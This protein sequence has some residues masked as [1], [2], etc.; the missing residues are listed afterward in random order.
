MINKQWIAL[1]GCVMVC[2]VGVPA[3]NGQ[4]VTGLLQEAGQRFAEGKT[5]EARQRYEAVV[6]QDSSCYEALAWLGNYFYLKGSDELSALER[7][8]KGV[9][10][11]TRMQ[12][13]RH[14][15]QL[16]A[17]YTQWY[18]KAEACINKALDVRKN[19]HLQHLLDEMVRFKERQGLLKA[20]EPRRRF[21]LL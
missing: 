17:V 21:R 7:A 14:Q 18:A 12:V 3:A 4:T 5:E 16:K 13:A 1:V 6:A 19:E 20:V 8:Y 9:R 11:P 10:E 15:E 2:L